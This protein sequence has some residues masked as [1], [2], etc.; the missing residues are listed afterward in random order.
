M[1]RPQFVALLLN[2]R[3]EN[4]VFGMAP[5]VRER[6]S[7]APIETVTPR[8]QYL[9]EFVDEPSNTHLIKWLVPQQC[10]VAQCN[11][12]VHIG[13]PY[14]REHTHAK[15]GVSV[16]MSSY[17]LPNKL[18]FCL[19]VS[20]EGGLPKGSIL[21][22][23]GERLT[24]SEIEKRYGAVGGPY[25]M[26]LKDGTFLDCAIV[27][28][29]AACSNAPSGDACANAIWVIDSETG[30]P[31]LQLSRPVLPGEEILLAYTDDQEDPDPALLQYKHRTLHVSAPMFW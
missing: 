23:S 18:D 13:G 7:R 6:L 16:L 14:C 28:C 29:A 12:F 11:T 25:L 8:Y 4:E 22:F 30:Q 31:E 24:D 15:Y 5:A 17:S 3:H 27:R 26:E 1:D 9:F 19:V 10:T 2:A 21:P 20:C